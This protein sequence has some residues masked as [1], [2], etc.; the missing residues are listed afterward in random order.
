MTSPA[1]VRRRRGRRTPGAIRAA[2]HLPRPR[3]GAE[4]DPDQVLAALPCGHR[5]WKRMLAAEREWAHI[6]DD[7]DSLQEIELTVQGKGYRLRTESKGT[8]QRVERWLGRCFVPELLPALL[9]RLE[10]L[11]LHD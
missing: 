5:D 1:Q 10:R 9:Q 3:S 7:L 6:L 11:P 2:P 8:R 4:P